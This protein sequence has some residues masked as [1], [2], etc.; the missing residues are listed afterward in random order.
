MGVAEEVPAV[1]RYTCDECG[2]AV[3]T[4]QQ[5]PDGWMSAERQLWP[6]GGQIQYRFL[7]C[8]ECA[9][10]ELVDVLVRIPNGPQIDLMLQSELIP[11]NLIEEIRTL[12]RDRDRHREIL[13]ASRREAPAAS[14]SWPPDA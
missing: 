13:A 5:L 4:A 10:H 1:W 7:Y 9:A 14:E 8:P 2:L 11:A 12:R 6:K 3:A